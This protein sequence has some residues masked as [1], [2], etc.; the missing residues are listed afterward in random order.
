MIQVMLLKSLVQVRNEALRYYLIS[1]FL[2]CGFKAAE[3]STGT[4]EMPVSSR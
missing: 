2:K 4:A 3:I 1:M